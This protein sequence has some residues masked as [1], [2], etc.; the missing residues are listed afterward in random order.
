MG[1]YYE[2]TIEEDGTKVRHCTHAVDNGLKLMEHSYVGNS[3][4]ERMMRIIENNPAKIMW[5]CD[6]TDEEHPWSWDNT[7]EATRESTRAIKPM[8]EASYFVVNN[9]KKMFID[10]AKYK[11]LYEFDPE[12]K[13]PLI[14]HPV[15]L[16][17]NSEDGSMGGGD[18]HQ[19]WS[20]RGAWAGD[21][22][23]TTNEEPDDS[24]KDVT[25]DVLVYER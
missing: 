21:E 19:E 3:Y 2:C 10:M 9:D 17:T 8:E 4:V 11:E 5:V 18:Y 14:I 20:Q 22:L 1:A 24:Y 7:A 16:L 6:Y 25:E 12:D 23:Y 15:P 13:W